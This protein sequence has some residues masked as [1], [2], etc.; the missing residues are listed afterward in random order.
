MIVR[1]HD[2]PPAIIWQLNGGISP[3]SRTIQGLLNEATQHTR[4]PISRSWQTFLKD[5]VHVISKRYGHPGWDGYDANPISTA[6]TVAALQLI[7]RLPENLQEPQ[8]V[9]EPD[10]EIAFEWNS[11]KD[12]LFSLTVSGPTLIY[13]GII[14]G[15]RRYGQERFFDELPQSIAQTLSNYFRKA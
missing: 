4:Q 3:E 8:V 13:A 11:G 1:H 12:M 10:G 2:E 15:N 6:S 5:N 7:D 14:G 9:P